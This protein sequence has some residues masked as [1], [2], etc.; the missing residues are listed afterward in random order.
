M[1]F[2]R[3]SDLTNKKQV[4][5]DTVSMIVTLL[6]STFDACPRNLILIAPSCSHKPNAKSTQKIK[7][8]K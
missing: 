5:C 6:P 3:K 4:R 1:L 7:L 2:L 8:K